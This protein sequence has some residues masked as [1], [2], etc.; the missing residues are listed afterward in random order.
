MRQTKI[1]SKDFLT[2]ELVY[3]FELRVSKDDIDTVGMA[4][5]QE[6]LEAVEHEAENQ[7]FQVSDK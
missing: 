6:K 7:G 1:T 4:K 5:I 3:T 2:S